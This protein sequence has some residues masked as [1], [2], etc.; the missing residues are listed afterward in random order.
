M[1]Y[2]AGAFAVAGLA[3]AAVPFLIHLLNRR[4]FRVVDWAAMDFLREALHRQRRFLRL[5]DIVLLALRT[6]CVLLFGFAMAR[7]YLSSSSDEVSL[8]QPLHAIIVVDNSLSSAYS[9]LSGTVLNA[10]KQSARTFINDLPD[11]SRVSI[12]PTC[13]SASSFS[14][15]A[16]A[17]SADALEALDALTPVD[18][19]GF[20]SGA[21]DNAYE[22]AQRVP[23]LESKRVVLI[24]DQQLVNWPSESLEKQLARL[25]EVQIVQVGPARRS[26]A[27]VAELHVQDGVAD[28]ET[29]TTFV[30]LVRYQGE[31]H[32]SRVPV[33]LAIEGTTVAT[34]EIDI[35]PGQTRELTF[36]HTFDIPLESGR[37]GY[38][39]VTMSIGGDELPLDD[40]RSIVVP[41]LSSLPVV[42]V[43]DVGSDENPSKN[44]YGE[45]IRLRRLM[46]PVTSR[47][48][49]SRQLI[50]V[51]HASVEDVDE[52]LLRDARLVVVA[53]IETPAMINGLL[54]EYV[55]QG[56][57]LVIAAGGDFDPAIWTRDAWL[58]GAGILPAPL[59][60][61]PIG[62]LPDIG[63]DTLDPFFLDVES[64]V[65]D[66]F[67]L[68]TE[69]PEGIADVYKEP[70]FFKAVSAI[71]ADETIA[72]LVETEIRRNEK[73]EL[74]AGDSGAD[75]LVWKRLSR[76]SDT[77]LT[78]RER[79]ERSRPR[80]LGRYTNGA[81]FIV[82]RRIGAGQVVLVTTGV[83][84][85]WSDLTKT[86][87]VFLFD[88]IFRTLLRQTLRNLDHETVETI[89]IPIETADRRASYRPERPD[90]EIEPLQVEARGFDRYALTIRDADQ[91]GFY[92][93]TA[94]RSEDTAGGETGQELWE[95]PV[96]AN[97]PESES[98]PDVV[99]AEMLSERLGEAK[100]R[101]VPRG[102]SIRLEGAL[103]SGVNIW[104]QLMGLVLALLLLE[105]L[106]VAWSRGAARRA[107]SGAV[108]AV[109]SAI[110]SSGRG[111]DRR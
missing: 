26:N 10:A 110:P 90:G 32:R 53:G 15:D 65:H 8:D 56:G 62:E 93:V 14:L 100:Y 87:A 86:H 60:D 75:W 44:L 111:G 1:A 43:D 95:L 28:T 101:W 84:S 21:M 98:R 71:V 6:I 54:R 48:E 72:E 51:R 13:G 55:E 30:G 16:Y 91:R 45:T 50:R 17:T 105:L 97:G 34:Q 92:V 42:F 41:V 18:A 35:E 22:A 106:V 76:S 5:R 107:S 57:Q 20:A 29:P 94:H 77:N 63:N 12:L 2:F 64:L 59:S 66:Y 3:L 104:K 102:E 74:T 73:M 40:Q 52:A 103:V 58:D 39:R 46:A 36:R 82:E 78:P 69:T 68:D 24:G 79:A 47:E 7:P 38:A 31:V 23:D 9:D 81:A 27:W 109:G 88:R 96:S 25:P 85:D 37:P 33:T 61:A 89:E 80:V 11:G 49:R 19:S 4:R 99:D 70:L 67:R 83:Y 108:A